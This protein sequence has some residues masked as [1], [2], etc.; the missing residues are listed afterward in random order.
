[1]GLRWEGNPGDTGERKERGWPGVSRVGVAGMPDTLFL[2][3]YLYL[4][5]FVFVFESYAYVFV[6]DFFVFGSSLGWKLLPGLEG[7]WKTGWGERP[8]LWP[9]P[10]NQNM[11]PGATVLTFK[12]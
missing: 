3:L 10:N 2:Y 6:L 11:T 1:V 7:G 5:V 4:E 12:F 8:G 9:A